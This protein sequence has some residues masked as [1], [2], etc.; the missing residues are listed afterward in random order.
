MSKFLVLIFSFLA[1]GCATVQTATFQAREHVYTADFPTAWAKSIEML[2]QEN[3][4]I[5]SMDKENGLIRTDYGKNPMQD[6]WIN[7]ARCSLNLLIT[8]VDAGHVRV[9]I[10]PSYEIY[11]PGP[12]GSLHPGQWVASNKKDKML[13]EKYFAVLDQKLNK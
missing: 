4:P 9:V 12:I 10:T 3:F 5:K 8:S 13:T 1:I 2:S 7:K 11:F 6:S